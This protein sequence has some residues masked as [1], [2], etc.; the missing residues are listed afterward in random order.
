M[1]TLFYLLGI[2]LFL[3]EIGILNN[4]K[5]HLNRLK[6]LESLNKENEQGEK[7]ADLAD[8]KR[9]DEGIITFIFTG[10]F[11]LAWDIIGVLFAGQ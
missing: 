8:L 11:Y 7:K 6:L 4:T 5:K 1:T 3:T 9:K 2:I 10:I